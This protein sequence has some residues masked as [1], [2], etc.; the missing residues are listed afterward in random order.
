[1]ILNNTNG[2]LVAIDGPNGAGK[3]ALIQ[4]IK[5]R[6]EEQDIPVFI[7]R[8]PTDSEFGSFVRA[9][10]EDH[11]GISLAC[12]VAADRYKHIADEILP[13]LK[14]GK[15]VITDRYLLSSLILQGMDGISAETILELNSDIVRPDLQIAVFATE[16]VLQ[17]RLSERSELTRFEKENQSQKEI[18]YMQQGIVELKKNN[19]PVLQID[20]NDNLEG[21]VKAIISCINERRRSS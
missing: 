3:S 17:R 9:F 18:D 19:I 14:K 11:T 2:F 21:N 13:E 6:M 12:M 20:N 7:T 10:S 1:M 15:I 16:G 4:A 8:E 5:Q